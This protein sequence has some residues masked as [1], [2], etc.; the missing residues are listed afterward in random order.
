VDTG[1]EIRRFEGHENI[2]LCTASSP[3]GARLLTGSR[4][5]AI[6]LWDVTTGSSIYRFDGQSADVR[7]ICFSPDGRQAISGSYDRTIALWRLP[8]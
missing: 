4:D 3:D 8:A 7:C 5:K 1:T 2:I 6:R